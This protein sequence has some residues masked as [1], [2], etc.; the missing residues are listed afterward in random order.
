MDPQV[1][2]GSSTVPRHVAIIM[3][4]NGRWARARELPRAI[5]HKNGAEMVRST[6]EA[7]IDYGIEYLTLFGFSSE[8]WNR[9]MDEVTDLMSLLRHYLSKEMVDLH[10]QG[11]R[12]RV[13]GQRERFAVDIISLIEQSE[14]LTST[15]ATLDLTLA[16]GY[17]GRWSIVQAARALAERCVEKTLMPQQ[18]CEE[19]FGAT[20]ET[21][22]LPEPDLMIR[23][24]GEK[25]VSNFMLWECAYTEFVF[26]DTLWPDFTREH[27]AAAIAEFGKRV[28]RYGAAT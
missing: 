13:I 7:A 21:N 20:L 4:G 27:F 3:D 8:N 28:R 19:L 2:Q 5:G 1:A 24:S 18:I 6:V 16:L 17:G 25:R 15:N 26:V 23:T 12:V 9:P 22:D 14:Q 10:S 11:V